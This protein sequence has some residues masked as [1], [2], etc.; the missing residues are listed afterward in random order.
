MLAAQ[1]NEY[2]GRTFS[3]LTGPSRLPGTLLTNSSLLFPLHA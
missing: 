3:R 2:S 1:L